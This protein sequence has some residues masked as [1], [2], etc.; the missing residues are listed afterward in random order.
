MDHRAVNLTDFEPVFFL[1]LV[2]AL[3]DNTYNTESYFVA[4]LQHGKTCAC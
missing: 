2:F 4:F 1:A 3:T